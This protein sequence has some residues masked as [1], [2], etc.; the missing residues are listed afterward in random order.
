MAR[1]PHPAARADALTDAVLALSGRRRLYTMLA[2]LL[3]IAVLA[4]GYDVSNEMNSGGFLT[5]LPLFFDY[6]AVLLQETWEKRADF[7]GHLVAFFPALLETL[8]IALVATLL[9]GAGAAIMSLLATR[10]LGAPGW[11]IAIT[12]RALDVMRAFPELIL[13]LFL[14]YVLGGSPVP[15][16]IAV[17]FHTAGALGKL[18]AEV[19][20]NIDARPLEGLQAGGASWIKRIRYGVLPQVAPNWL[21]YFLLRL[22]INV[23]ASAILGFVGAGGIG[24]ELRRTI[25]WGLGAGDETIALFTLLIISIF[26]ID[27]FSSWGRARLAGKTGHEA[28]SATRPEDAR[29]AQTIRRR[30]VAT[31]LA[32]LLALAYLS[33]A[34]F[35]FDVPGLIENARPERA[36]ILAGDSVSHKV[37]VT[38]DMRRG[39]IEA[40]VEGERRATYAADALPLWISMEGEESAKV[41]LG[42]GVLARIDGKVLTL[43][44]PGYG[45]ITAT[46]S[47]RGV[48]TVLPAG[49]KPDWV[50]AVSNKL[51]V[52]TPQGPRAQVSK[53]RIEL[54]RFF[55]G[56]EHFWFEF[57]SPLQGKS[58][59]ELAALAVSGAR[60]EPTM[61]NSWFIL[62]EFLGNQEW[63]HREVF[64]ALFETLMMALLGTLTAAFI[65]LP[66]AALA[67]RNFTPSGWV[68]FFTRRLFDLLRGIDML[69]WSLIFIRAFGLGPLTG[70]LAI[71]FTDTGTLGKLFSEA[72]ENVDDRQ[73]EGVHAAGA[74]RLQKWRYGVLPQIAPVFVSQGLY[75]LESNTRSATV[76]GALGAGGIGLLLVETLRTSKD[77]ENTAYIVMLT[78][79]LV[80]VMDAVSTRL[81]RR[82]IEGAARRGEIRAET[83][84]PVPAAA[85]AA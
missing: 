51:D 72:L 35:A 69:I 83:A 57:G 20:E 19:N 53:A 65:G 1:T 74:T 45:E 77:W 16:M 17:A 34:W 81:R 39:G 62:Q 5:G 70:A 26:A 23:R 41:D 22:E 18:F 12:R 68:R 3:L 84:A 56:W 42:D 8:N 13:A 11:M 27:Q 71:A 63:Q 25:G 9:G 60:I 46:A 85:Q 48:E 4:S 31:A 28:E 30:S 55:W 82:L 6:P 29:I 38:A 43:F 79:L 21:S 75:Y 37:H 2:A 14:I 61:S 78:I 54:H 66:L 49:P 36:A 76:I 7:P 67:A 40:S 24:T 52:R 32:P 58:V 73:I 33:Y 47:R 80:S 50:R 10:G 15:A 59:S 44:V 64:I